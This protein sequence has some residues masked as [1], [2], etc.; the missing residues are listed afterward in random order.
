MQITRQNLTNWGNYPRCDAEVATP[1][2]PEEAVDYVLRTPTLIARGNG[3]CYGDAALGDRVLSTL[4]LNRILHFDPT[5][6]I[7]ECESGVLLR[8]LIPLIVP[9]GW[10]FH[11]TPGIKNITVGGAI[12]SDVHGKNHLLKG[13]FSDWLE[14]FDLL[15][16]DGQVVR[17]SKTERPDLF[18]QTCGGMGWTGVILRARFRLAPLASVWMEQ[19]TVRAG[20]LD[21][22]FDAFAAHAA[23]PYAA[24]WV[25][26]LAGG[27]RQGR[28]VAYF[29]RH[30][31]SGASSPLQ[32]AEEKTANVPV[33]A[34]SWL[35]N[36]WT[37]GVHN[38]LRF[39]GGRPRT[40]PVSLDRYFYPLDAIQ[41]W[42]RLY[43]RRGFIQYQFCLPEA[44]SSLGIRR[45]LECIRQRGEPP[46]LSVLKRHGAR[47]P[48]AVHSFPDK[49]F[50]LAL[51]FPMSEK[52]FD[53]VRALDQLVWAHGGKIY[54]A[55]DACSAPE[56]G[57]VRPAD[58]GDP[59]FVSALRQRIETRR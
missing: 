5:E 39:A 6:G 7:L 45:V 57:R 50:S 30:L 49:G 44:E 4:K 42:N 22:L 33:F 41:N 1:D 26:C 35:L 46:F 19:T 15:L 40:A 59:K 13:C 10:F 36:A 21:A 25:D 8:D 12:A 43:G 2:R 37:I 52:I 34:P 23:Q 29:A 3:K 54:L 32:Y 58:F 16:S 55:K 53:L 47:R 11:V 28:G 24:A 27:A 56:M 14:C 31:E 17:C 18:W 38:A 9:A 48:E 20:G 51:D